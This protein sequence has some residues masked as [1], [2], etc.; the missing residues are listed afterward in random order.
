MRRL[1]LFLLLPVAALLFSGCLDASVRS[2]VRDHYT[3]T[4]PKGDQERGAEVFTSSKKPSTV[5]KDIAD[6]RKPG[7]RHSSPSGLLLRYSRD[8]VAVIPDGRGGSRIVIED[9]RRGYNHFY[10][11]VGGWWGT[12]SGRGESFRGGGPGAGK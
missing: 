5:A 12:Y 10:P 4:K 8:V 7:D 3:K 11:I 9:E 6:H 1:R 2:Y